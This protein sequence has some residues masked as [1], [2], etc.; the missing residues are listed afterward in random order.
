MELDDIVASILDWIP[1]ID[2]S[3]TD[4]VVSVFET[5]IRYLGGMLSGELLLKICFPRR[6]A[7]IA[8]WRNQ[9]QDTICSKVHLPI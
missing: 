7:G 2:F 3:Q 1:T 8:D 4:S 5:T 6:D 9:L